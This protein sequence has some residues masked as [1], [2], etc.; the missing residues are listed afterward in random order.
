MPQS[1]ATNNKKK[2]NICWQSYILA[3]T[4]TKNILTVFI[5][6]AKEKLI[7]LFLENPGGISEFNK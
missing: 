3:I 7:F 6:V 1:V 5:C 4:L 2:N